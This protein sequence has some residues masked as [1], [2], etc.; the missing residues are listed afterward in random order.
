VAGEEGVHRL[1]DF[2]VEEVSL[3]DRAANKRRFLMVKREGGESMELRSNGRGGFTRVMKAEDEETE[4][5]KGKPF[6]GAAKPFGK[7]EDGEEEKAKKA[8]GEEGD[9]E[10]ARKLLADAG[11]TDA[12]KR[13][14]ANEGGSDDERK[15]RAKVDAEGMKLASEV[16]KLAE[17]L[18]KVAEDMKGEEADEPSDVHMKKCMAMHKK[19]GA[20]CEKYTA[21]VGKAA[22]AKV[23]AKMAASRLAS[24]K[25]SLDSLQSILA[26]LLETPSSAKEHEADPGDPTKPAAGYKPNNPSDAPTNAMGKEAIKRLEGQMVKM[27]DEIVSPLIETCKAQTAELSKLR[28]SVLGST[29][30][31]V[32]KR[33]GGQRESVAWPMDMARAVNGSSVNKA[34]S[35]LDD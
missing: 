33:G 29:A 22:V 30:L 9:E 27:V 17:E 25:A 3:V 24:F 21:K 11:L 12:A 28:K 26:E 1:T 32:E 23:G 35:F 34:E 20:I 10:K 15:R 18:G 16:A 31:P 13:V 5:A 2:V 14:F 8:D 7:P 4:K 6:P 19:L